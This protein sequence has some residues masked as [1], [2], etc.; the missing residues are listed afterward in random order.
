L[1][2]PN[3][4]S[5]GGCGPHAD[6]LPKQKEPGD[7]KTSPHDIREKTRPNPSVARKNGNVQSTHKKKETH[8]QHAKSHQ[9]FPERKTP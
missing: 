8:A 9:H 5:L 4:G 6:C 1:R 3:N 7:Q 2:R